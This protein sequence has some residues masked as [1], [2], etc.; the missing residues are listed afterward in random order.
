MSHMQPHVIWDEF[1]KIAKEE[2]GSQVV[3]TWF[4]AVSLRTINLNRGE[5]TLHMPNSFVSNWIQEHY[6]SLLI[7]HLKRLLSLD[8]VTI[9]F[10]GTGEQKEE[11]EV[12]A[13]PPVAKGLFRPAVTTQMG[14]TALV[15]KPNALTTKPQNMGLNENYVF[16][17]FV[18]GPS[19]SLAHGAAYAVSQALGTVYNPLFIYGGTGLGK[20]HLLHAI[21]NEAKRI[22][23]DAQV[24][25]ET[26]DHF[27]HEF[28]RSIRFDRAHQ[29]RE[30]Y[31]NIDLL[32]ID[33]IQFFSNKEQTQETF[34]HI[35][36]VLHEKKKQI[37]LSSDTFPE[38]IKGLQSRLTSR[39]EWG[40]VADMQTPDLETK[41]AILNK[42]AEQHSIQLSD[43]VSHFIAS[44][45]HTN[46]RQLEG[47]LI[48][49]DAFSSL[50][51]QELSL[52]LAKRVLLNFNEPRPQSLELHDI[53]H[54]VAKNYG[55]T[56]AD[57][58]SRNRNKV[59][60]TA[61][62][63]ACFMMKKL[64][65]QSLQVIGQFLNGRDHSTVIHAITATEEKMKDDRAFN[66][67]IQSIEEEI[68]GA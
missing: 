35:F 11:T 7:T 29:F 48:R 37:V 25:Y 44:R 38:E 57:L 19:N 52:S 4:K 18:V 10:S 59:I 3:E 36:N 55:V 60:A 49:V 56:M 67:K 30:R 50:T 45:V 27:M 63:V 66:A 26:S 39:M 23:P 2:A 28:I 34:F 64:T 47:A 22:N 14:S 41:V 65:K 8:A 43:E 20:T 6:H 42:K 68:M 9:L 21:G 51:G 1:L 24:R 33:D 17:S 15:P 40:L 61:R 16:D 54:H 46:I 5:V 12:A 62:Q 13:T 58:K 53:A 31:L 32:L